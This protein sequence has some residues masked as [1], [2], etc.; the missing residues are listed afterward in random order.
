MFSPYYRIQITSSTTADTW[1]N[2]CASSTVAQD[3]TY[4]YKVFPA[5]FHLNEKAKKE[6]PKKH[7]VELF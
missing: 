7:A 1:Q 3:I 2:D 6:P 5:Y 4:D